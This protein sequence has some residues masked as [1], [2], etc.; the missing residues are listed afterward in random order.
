[1]RKISST[2]LCD[3]EHIT[4][5]IMFLGK[6]QMNLLH[7]LFIFS[8]FQDTEGFQK[9]NIL[10]IIKALYPLGTVYGG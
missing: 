8:V 7:L 6:N 4:K 2:K 1:M 5:G 9:N 10:H 3:L